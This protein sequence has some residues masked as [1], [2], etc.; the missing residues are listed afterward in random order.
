MADRS[1]PSRVTTADGVDIELAWSPAAEP[2][3]AAVVTHPHPLMGGDMH[4][5]VPAGVARGLAEV[6]VTAVRLSFRGAGGSSGEHGG[7]EAERADVAAAVD[8]LVDALP[9]VPVVGVGYSF[10]ADVLL[11]TEHPAL[12]GVV[13][14]A[15][16]LRVLPADAMAA[17]RGGV[18][19]LVLT[20]AH[21][22]FCSPE[23]AR[24]VTSTWAMTAVEEVAG[25]D[26]FL[27]GGV[28]R[29]V[30]RVVRFVDDLA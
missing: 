16:P 7:G 2:R 5:P 22:Q 1:A 20:P 29:V 10:G 27:A 18:P 14:V 3:A 11:G 13:A 17:L 21:D 19:T 30:D 6:G 23:Q 9:G 28:Q 4:N 15:P 26:H 25:C 24:L 12:A 8:A